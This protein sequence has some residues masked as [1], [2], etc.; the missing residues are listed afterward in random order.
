[1]G[2]ME[3]PPYR[4]GQSQTEKTCINQKSARAGL[5][6]NSNFL[7]K[8]CYRLLHFKLFFYHW[9]S[10]SDD[11]VSFFAVTRLAGTRKKYIPSTRQVEASRFLSVRSVHTSTGIPLSRTTRAADGDAFRMVSHV[12]TAGA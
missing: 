10:T 11:F 2:F 3:A 9:I 1:M 7:G 8:F 5:S 4:S 6:S 12:Y